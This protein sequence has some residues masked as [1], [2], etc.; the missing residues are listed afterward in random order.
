M[1]WAFHGPNVASGNEATVGG[2][3]SNVAS[4]DDATVPGGYSN[5]AQGSSSFAAGYS[6]KALHD[7]AFV[8]SDA[9]TSYFDPDV[10]STAP[11]QFLVRAKGGVTF[12]TSATLST[13]VTVAATSRLPFITRALSFGHG[14]ITHLPVVKLS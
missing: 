3:D 1:P 11:N 9:P 6:A 12:Y 14:G 2:G 8:W 7:G 4:G 10:S 5:T 13:G